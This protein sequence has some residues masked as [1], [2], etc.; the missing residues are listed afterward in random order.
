MW[1]TYI[2]L[3]SHVFKKLETGEINFSNK[4]YSTQYSQNI[5][6]FNK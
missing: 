3:N 5:I 1:A 6:I 4:F 2:I